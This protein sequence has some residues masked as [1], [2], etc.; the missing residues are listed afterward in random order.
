MTYHQRPFAPGNRSV[1]RCPRSI[2]TMVVARGST[3]K[4]EVEVLEATMSRLLEDLV[5]ALSSYFWRRGAL[6][7]F[8]SWASWSSS[9][10]CSAIFL[11]QTQTIKQSLIDTTKLR[12]IVLKRW[13]GQHLYHR[14]PAGTLA[15]KCCLTTQLNT[16]ELQGKPWSNHYETNNSKPHKS[17]KST[18]F[19]TARFLQICPMV[20]TIRGVA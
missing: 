1:G 13:N 5:L 15:Y 8:S 3:H 7:P 10:T 2:L 12:S 17:C 20:S 18:V 16:I 11:C 4:P 9:R 6:S 19:L 14:T